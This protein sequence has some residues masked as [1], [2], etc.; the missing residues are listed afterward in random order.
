MR[1]QC[2]QCGR[3]GFNKPWKLAQHV[4]FQHPKNGPLAILPS[5]QANVY[6][7]NYCPNCGAHLDKIDLY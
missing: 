2:K 5:Q 6:R 4:K 7:T 3:R 1:L